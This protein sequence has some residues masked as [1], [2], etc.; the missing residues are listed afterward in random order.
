M[1]DYSDFCAAIADTGLTPLLDLLPARINQAF[2]PDSHGDMQKWQEALAQ[3]PGVKARSIELD[4]DAVK[5]GAPGECDAATRQ[6]IEV[7]L[8]Q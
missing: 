3:L 5:I 8:R 2:A 1:I 7:L 6:E 4:S